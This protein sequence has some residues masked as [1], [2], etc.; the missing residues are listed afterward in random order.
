MTG[1]LRTSAAGLQLIKSF[2]GF[3]EIASQLPGGRWTIG[4]GHV[5]TA[6]EGLTIT[7]KDAEDLLVLDLKPVED[8]I[9]TSVF[10]PLMQNQFDALVS[11]VFNIS[12]AQFRESDI[13]RNLNSGDFLAA[14]NGF[15]LWRRAR[16]NGRVMVVDALVRRRAAEKSLFLDHPSGRVAAPTPVVKPE[17]DVSEAVRTT[18]TPDADD[19]AAPRQTPQGGSMDIAEAVRRLAERTREAITPAPEIP[20]PQGAV[21]T[22]PETTRQPEPQPVQQ[23]QPPQPKTPEDIQRAGRDIAERVRVILQRAEETIVAQPESQPSARK[24]PEA[25]EAPHHADNENERVREGMPD[26][27][28]PVE[29]ATPSEAARSRRLIDDTETFDPGRR[30]EDIFAEAERKA[31]VV[32][33][34]ARRVGPLS[35]RL[36]MHAPWIVVLVLS[37]VGFAIGAVEVMR[38]SADGG[39]P[40]LAGVAL[41]AFGVMLVMSV[42]FIFWN[43]DTHDHA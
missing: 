38:S 24:A 10:A 17:M 39:A 4:H 3:R 25:V 42:S 40:Q 5:R 16:L 2:E 36:I 22:P 20:L 9:A 34:Q 18:Y 1:R 11:L 26:F 19:D 13:L 15:D 29:R 14:A 35:G 30:P 8:A 33:G 32:N 21:V 31:Q 27:D 7:E 41:A 6:R 43:R 28:A 37:L 12:P 23:V